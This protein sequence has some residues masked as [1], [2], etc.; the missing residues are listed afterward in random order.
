MEDCKHGREGMPG[1]EG[2]RGEWDQGHEREGEMGRANK[3]GIVIGIWERRLE[4]LEEL[5][6]RSGIWSE[7]G[8]PM[9]GVMWTFRAVAGGSVQEQGSAKRRD[10]R[11]P[12]NK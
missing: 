12:C 11:L 5:G 1:K 7:Q 6:E 9:R 8:T 3:W 10:R 4:D 2:E